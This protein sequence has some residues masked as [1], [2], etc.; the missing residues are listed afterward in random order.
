MAASYTNPG[1]LTITQ[2]FKIKE[3]FLNTMFINRVLNQR[4]IFNA[5]FAGAFNMSTEFVS[6]YRPKRTQLEETPDLITRTDIADRSNPELVPKAVTESQLG[7][8]KCFRTIGPVSW[9]NVSLRQRQMSEAAMYAWVAEDAAVQMRKMFRKLALEVLVA[10]IKSDSDKYEVIKRAVKPTDVLKA[11][12]YFGEYKNLWALTLMPDEM[13][14]A[15]MEQMYA[16]KIGGFSGLAVQQDQIFSLGVPVKALVDSNLDV[17]DVDDQDA[18][19]QKGGRMLFLPRDDIHVQM[20]ELPRWYSQVNVK[21]KMISLDIQAEF[22]FVFNVRQHEW[23]G[24]PGLNADDNPDDA[25]LKNPAKWA[26]R[27]RSNN[28]SIGFLLEVE[29]P[30]A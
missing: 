7:G 4:D 20:T 23:I 3:E 18:G 11:K 13:K 8:I 2:D 16:D 29:Y 6:G 5:E 14:T 22:D 24:T 21:R 27:A 17:A 26:E 9:T 19:A 12:K 28:N 25:K 1:P 10:L 30:P 15:I